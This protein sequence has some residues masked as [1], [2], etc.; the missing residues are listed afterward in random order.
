MH[1]T[2]TA[3]NTGTCRPFESSGR[4]GTREIDFVCTGRWPLKH[5]AD[6]SHVAAVFPAA[7]LAI[8]AESLILPAS[9]PAPG[10]TPPP[11]PASILT[12]PPLTA[13]ATSD[14]TAAASTAT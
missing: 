1:H 5:G 13:A 10:P 12:A 6:R 9:G 8:G 2:A 3:W 7:H 11:V 14:P 4:T